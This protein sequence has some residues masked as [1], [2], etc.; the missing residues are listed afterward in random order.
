MDST[1]NDSSHQMISIERE[2]VLAL[3]RR[4]LGARLTGWGMLDEEAGL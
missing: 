3:W 1:G 2:R 4:F